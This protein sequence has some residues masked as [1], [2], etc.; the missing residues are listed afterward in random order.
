MRALHSTLNDNNP[1][2]SKAKAFSKQD[3]TS[4]FS[5]DHIPYNLEAHVLLDY[6]LV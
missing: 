1:K 4:G 3:A 6:A 5:S 2:L